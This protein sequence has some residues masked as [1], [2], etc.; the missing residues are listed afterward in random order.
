MPRTIMLTPEARPAPSSANLGWTVHS[1]H[2]DDIGTVATSARCGNPAAPGSSCCMRTEASGGMTTQGAS[3]DHAGEVT[4]E[5]VAT[6][7]LTRTYGSTTAVDAIDLR[8]HAGEVYGFLGANGAGKTTAMRM[9]LGLARPTAGTAT[10]LG[11]PAGDRR[12]LSRTGILIE[13]PALYPYLSGRENLRAVGRYTSI[14]DRRSDHVL[15][16]VG[17]TQAAR[18][19]V[20]SY[21]LGMRQ[22]LG[23]AIALLKD[24]E[25]LVLDEPTNG[26]DPGGIIAMREL[27]A[28]LAAEGR[29]VLI[30]SH[31]LG[32]VDQICDR[33]GILAEGQLVAQG[34]VAD[35]RGDG[36]LVINLDPV[37]PALALLRRMY[38]AE[39]AVADKSEVRLSVP[40]DQSALVNRTLHEAGIHVSALYWRERSLADAFFSL[41]GNTAI[42]GDR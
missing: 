38:G 7:G 39:R 35:I 18:R 2:R 10:V 8:V 11:Q 27:I 14:G 3:A 26:L 6:Q 21:S 5:A 34:T 31:A 30:S 40:R 24:P 4:S 12:A 41:T 9:L 1:D 33:V 36:A 20:W 15:E 23:V 28:G 42:G 29:T 19:R 37:E 22:R 16:T 25:L 17:L 32:E 13:E